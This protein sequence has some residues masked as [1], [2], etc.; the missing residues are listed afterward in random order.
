MIASLR[1][2]I[3]KTNPGELIV[4]VAGVGYAVSVP[5]DTWDTLRE[6]AVTHL[7]ISTY[8]REDRFELYGFADAHTKQLFEELT[9]I[10]GIGPRMGLELCGVPRALLLQAINEDDPAMLTTVKGIGRK[11]AEKLLVELKSLAEKSPHMFMGEGAVHGARYDQDTIAALS[12]LG[13]ATQ[14]IMKVLDDLPKDLQTTEERVTA[15]L[16]S[17]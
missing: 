5:M 15:A 8:V 11:T 14:D 4:D 2:T 7:F 16:R 9:Q 17:L 3:S 13:F 12:Q 1:G 6:A 10:S